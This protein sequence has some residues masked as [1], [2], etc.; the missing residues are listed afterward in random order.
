MDR[1]TRLSGI[2]TFGWRYGRSVSLGAD[3]RVTP[4]A[5]P[6]AMIRVAD[7]LP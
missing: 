4:L 7:L 6:E 1:L 2:D 5:V 3:D